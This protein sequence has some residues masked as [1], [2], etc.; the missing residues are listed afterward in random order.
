MPLWNSTINLQNQH[1]NPSKN[2]KSTLPFHVLCY[3]FADVINSR[4]SQHG[5]VI[6]SL[7][8]DLLRD[9]SQQFTS[10]PLSKE[11]YPL[12]DLATQS[13]FRNLSSD[14]A[15]FAQHAGRRSIEET[16]VQM[17]MQRQRFVKG[18][19][20]AKMSVFSVAQRYLP[21]EL[22]GRVRMVKSGAKK[23]KARG[24]KRKRS[25]QEEQVD[26]E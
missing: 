15:T 19:E 2:K 6:P 5:I 3:L 25:R 23:G 13:F 20:G 18:G 14:L 17:L 12:L 1:A 11:C 16:D 26:A 7:P 9:L 21:G 8:R 22:L 24:T 10:K 4:L